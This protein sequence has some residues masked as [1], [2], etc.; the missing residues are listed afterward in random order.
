MPNQRENLTKCHQQINIFLLLKIYHLVQKY[1]L[2]SRVNISWKEKVSQSQELTG[3]SSL[4]INSFKFTV[5]CKLA[6]EAGPWFTATPLQITT[7]F[8]QTVMPSPL[9]QTG[10]PAAL[11]FQSQPPLHSVSHH[12]GLLTG[13]FGRTLERISWSNP[14]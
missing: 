10:L 13:M 7:I 9:V 14:T 4:P 3:S 12:L 8:S 2:E 1:F 5:T 6:G 11:T